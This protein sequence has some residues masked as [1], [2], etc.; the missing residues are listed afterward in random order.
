VSLLLGV[1]FQVSVSVQAPDTV[2]ARAPATMTIRATAPGNTAP[3]LTSPTVTGAS[4]QLV[5]DLV[6]LGGGFGQ[7]VA[8]REVRYQLRAP[9]AGRIVISQVAATLGREQAL[10]S[11]KEIVVLPPPRNAVPSI[12]LR[13]PLVRTEGI[14]FHSMVSPDTVWAGEQVTVQVGVFIDA[15]LRSRLQRNPEY[16]APS[17]EGAVAFD[18]PV[19]NDAL[20]SRTVDG[21]RYQPY[22]YPRALFPLRAGTLTIPSSRLGYSIGGRT[23]FGREERKLATTAPRSV[24]VREIPTEG[25]PASFTGAV[26][27]YTMSASVERASGRVGDAVQL[28]VRVDGVGNIKLLPAPRLAL[29]GVTVNASGENISVDTSDLLVRGSKTFRYQLTPQR[30]GDIPLG[31]VR[32]AFFNPVRGEYQELAAALGAI[33]VAPGSIAADE[34]LDAAGTPVLPLQPWGAD[35]SE[36]VTDTWWYRT[37]ILALGAPWLALIGLRIVRAIRSRR[38]LERRRTSRRVVHDTTDPAG[39]R[40]DFIEGLTPLIALRRDQPV[41]VD[42]V[43][44]RLRKVGVTPSA[45]EAAGAMLARLDQL[46]FGVT[47]PPRADLIAALL[48][49]SASVQ[50]QLRTEISASAQQRFWSFARSVPLLALTSGLLQAQSAAFATGL[51]EYRAQHYTA[52]A[53]A[54]AESARDEPTNAA[55]WTNLGAAHWM[56]ADT[57]GA[58]VAWQRS[59]RLAPRANRAVVW[60]GQ[61]MPTSDLQTMIAP[62]TPNATWLLLLGVTS[63]LSVLGALTRFRKRTIS[64]AALIAAVVAVGACAL[65]SVFAQRSRDAVGLVVVRREVA[66]RNEPLLAGE[67]GARARGGELAIVKE[68]RGTWRFVEV[69]SGRSGWVEG[70][71]VRSIAYADGREVAAAELRI[72]TESAEP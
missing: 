7:A 66:L 25:R 35:A 65:L 67:A 26:G 4:L 28:S 10:S 21:I 63:L 34:G 52:A 64:N 33:R 3:Q 5:T 46:T 49:E 17:V 39:I 11:V 2:T 38:R 55:V 19:A 30:A 51:K 8:T 32:Y 72:A 40:R 58:I 27:V 54:F 13:A 47:A 6:R 59:A 12:V 1:L 44:R 71:A 18:L 69:S 9:V 37:L 31:D 36:D 20:A 24:F 16:V 68:S 23:I 42:E 29:Q 57:A 48:R 15:E 53:A 50:E 41:G 70:D 56:R 45:A 14:N 61:R 60:L 22:V 43:V 62:V